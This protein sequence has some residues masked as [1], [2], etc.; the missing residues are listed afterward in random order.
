M[1]TEHALHRLTEEI[2]HAWDQGH[3]AS[4]LL[5]DVSGAF[6][7]VSHPRLLHNL[8]KCRVDEKTVGWI[9]SF[10]RNRKTTIQLREH[11]TELL[12]IDTGIPQGSPISPILYLFYN[13]DILEDAIRG[14]S[15]TV[16]GGWVDDVYF[17]AHSQSTEQ[18]CRKLLHMHQKAERWSR[19]HGSRFD[20]GKYQLVHLTRELGEYNTKQPLTLSSTTIQPSFSARYLGI[21]LDQPL[22]WGPH[23]KYVE[24]KARTTL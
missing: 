3:V 22:R 10:S 9:A 4:L 13:A 1:S 20:L 12:S 7:H 2:H 8:R 6:D 16:T 21:V 24:G 11:T 14:V 18:N 19:T 23:V 15:D 17:L 5:L